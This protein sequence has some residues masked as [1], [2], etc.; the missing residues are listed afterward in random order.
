M[1]LRLRWPAPRGDAARARWHGQ[2]RE[3]E[4]GC[5]VE[6]SSTARLAHSRMAGCG[7]PGRRGRS[8]GTATRHGDA[9]PERLR[10]WPSTEM[11]GM[12]AG[13]PSGVRN[14]AAHGGD[15][16]GCVGMQWR[17]PGGRA[18]RLGTAGI[19]GV[20]RQ[21]RFTGADDSEAER[22][23]AVQEDSPAPGGL[24]QPWLGAATRPSAS[25]RTRACDRQGK[26][27]AALRLSAQ[28]RR[29]HGE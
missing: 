1:R 14:G 27:A 21:E 23:R 18:A 12:D 22:R 9:R 11:E 13:V 2:Q 5:A 24:A 16:D 19:D 6:R 29:S 10:R 26:R 20:A 28:A 15:V 4:R 8:T 17:W 7:R 3:R 25:G